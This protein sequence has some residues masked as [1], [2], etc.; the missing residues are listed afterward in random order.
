MLHYKGN[1]IPYSCGCNRGSATCPENGM[2][3]FQVKVYYD[4]T[5]FECENIRI[6]NNICDYLPNI[7]IPTIL[8]K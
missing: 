1:T 3:L 6:Y 2:C 7:E 5:T 4:F 8:V